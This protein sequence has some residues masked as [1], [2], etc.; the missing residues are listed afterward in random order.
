[1]GTETPSNEKTSGLIT[2]NRCAYNPPAI[3]A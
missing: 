3:P 2:E 1:M